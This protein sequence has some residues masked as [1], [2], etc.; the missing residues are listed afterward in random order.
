MIYFGQNYFTIRELGVFLIFL[1]TIGSLLQFKNMT[2][3]T[4]FQPISLMVVG[5][6][7]IIIDDIFILRSFPLLLSIFFF[8]AFIYAH[9]TKDFF[10]IKTIEKF[11]KLDNSERLYLEKTHTIWI[12]VTAINVS[13]HIYFLFF[14]SMKLWTFYITIGWY[15]LLGC[16]I[17]FQIGFRKFYEHKTTH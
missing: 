10:L 9:I 2:M 4:L 11:K 8:L 16:G 7:S 17:L 6:A 5:M 15:I 3:K 14:T 13:L 12:V 1:G